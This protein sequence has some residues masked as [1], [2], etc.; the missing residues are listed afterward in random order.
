MNSQIPIISSPG[1]NFAATLWMVQTGPG[2][3]T[4]NPN[5]ASVRD[6]FTTLRDRDASGKCRIKE[7]FPVS[8]ALLINSVSLIQ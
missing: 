1:M 7:L 8:C 3:D 5:F 6:F 2:V 4:G